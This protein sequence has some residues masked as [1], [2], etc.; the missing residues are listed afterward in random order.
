MELSITLH[1]LHQE[2]NK[3][4][5]MLGRASM[6]VVEDMMRHLRLEAMG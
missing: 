6:P 1:K 2:A 5:K 4:L 3:P